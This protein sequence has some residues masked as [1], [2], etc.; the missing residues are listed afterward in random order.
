MLTILCPSTH[1]ALPTLTLSQYQIKGEEIM[2]SLAEYVDGVVRVPLRL[3]SSDGFAECPSVFS[4]QAAVMD[5]EQF[6]S[7]RAAPITGIVTPE[8]MMLML[9]RMGI[10]LARFRET[11]FAEETPFANHDVVVGCL[12]GAECLTKA[13]AALGDGF[14]CVV[15]VHCLPSGM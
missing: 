7:N 15:R 13:K 5:F 3:L 2:S 12:V 4:T 6:L 11:R 8:S 9:R 1:V 10:T 14:E